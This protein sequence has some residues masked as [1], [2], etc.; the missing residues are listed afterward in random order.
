M[1]FNP[2]YCPVGQ[3]Y[4]S[5]PDFK[6]QMFSETPSTTL[7]TSELTRSGVIDYVVSQFVYYK[8]GTSIRMQGVYR[9]GGSASWSETTYRGQLGPVFFDGFLFL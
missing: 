6:A 8:K 9:I 1:A 7:T 4:W 3:K 2:Q 5:A